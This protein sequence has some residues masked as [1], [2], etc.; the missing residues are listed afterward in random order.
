MRGKLYLPAT[1]KL[2]CG[3]CEGRFSV[4]LRALDGRSEIACP[5]CSVSISI[6]RSLEPS[7]RIL[8]YRAARERVEE[9]VINALKV[10]GDVRGF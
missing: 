10:E 1:I 4:G 8:L 9:R 2:T 5:F 7:V 6:Y 3:E